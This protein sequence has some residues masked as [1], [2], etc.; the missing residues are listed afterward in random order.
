MLVEE[1]GVGCQK[2]DRVNH[3]SHRRGYL[4]PEILVYTVANLES[5]AALA[6]DVVV[7]TCA[8]AG[9]LVLDPRCIC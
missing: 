1:V 4:V 2:A 3:F 8:C 7:P 5:V 6:G 9:I